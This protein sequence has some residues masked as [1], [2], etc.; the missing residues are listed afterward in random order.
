MSSSVIFSKMLNAISVIMFLCKR[1]PIRTISVSNVLNALSQA[2]QGFL[3]RGGHV[4][5]QA[6]AAPHTV[7]FN[8]CVCFACADA[9]AKHTHWFSTLW[10]PQAT[11]LYG[12]MAPTVLMLPFPCMLAGEAGHVRHMFAVFAGEACKNSK[13]MPL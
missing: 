7:L 12:D 10:S 8:Q 5:V 13:H 11:N 2:T 1:S 3:I 6:A 9:H 4:P